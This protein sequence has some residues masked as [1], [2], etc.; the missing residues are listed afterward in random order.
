MLADGRLRKIAVIERHHATGNIGVGLIAGYGLAHGAIATTVAH[1][2]H[3]LIVVGDNDA[4][5]LAAVREI[6]RVQGGYTIVRGGRVLGTLPLPV[7]GLMSLDGADTFIPALD[8]MIDEARAQGVA[9]GIDPFI[10]LSF[11]ALPVIPEIRI[12]DIG[13]FD[14]VNFRPLRPF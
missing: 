6:E 3:N 12:T 11:M 1:D 8:R 10:T 2:S 13:L 4:D 9:D 14:V 5:M 7:A